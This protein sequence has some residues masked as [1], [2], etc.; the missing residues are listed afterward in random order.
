VNRLTALATAVAFAAAALLSFADPAS[1]VPRACTDAVTDYCVEDEVVYPGASDPEPAPGASPAAPEPARESTGGPAP[2]CTWE[3]DPG[4]LASG[5]GGPGAF[6]NIRDRPSD[7][8][9]LVFE[10]CNGEMSGSV[11]WVTPTE[12]GPAPAGAPPAPPSPSALA[13]IIRVRLE[14]NLPEP[15]AATSPAAGE[16]A[17]VN[18]PSFLAIDNWT[19]T[20][21]DDECALLLCVTVTATPTLTWSPGEPGAPTITCAGGGTRFDPHGAPSQDQAAAPGACA[22]AYQ[23]RTGTNG[24]PDQWPGAATVTWDLTW[25][26][27][28][29]ASGSLDPVVRTVDV[30]RSVDEVQAIVVR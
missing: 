24:R 22:H 30:S 2:R 16:A 10:W 28:T 25:T 13:A 14:G 3:T 26:S 18:H 7:D 27:T 29:G 20:V 19:G 23:S 1:G 5:D 6:P 9:Y 17:I 21:T 8:A 12:P 4:L 11:D 15:V